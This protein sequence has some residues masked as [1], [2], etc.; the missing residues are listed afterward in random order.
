MGHLS[1]FT[2]PST[3]RYSSALFGR[4]P[5]PVLFACNDCFDVYFDEKRAAIEFFLCPLES[6]VG[7]DGEAANDD[8]VS[9]VVA[10]DCGVNGGN[11]DDE[12]E[13]CLSLRLRE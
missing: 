9:I 7:V 2:E 8:G 6:D 13:S 11:N 12:S 10:A 4:L 5:E 1:P 3:E